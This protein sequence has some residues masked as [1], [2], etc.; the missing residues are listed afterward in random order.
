MNPI[1]NTNKTLAIFPVEA[2]G[3]KSEFTPKDPKTAIK[4][5]KAAKTRVQKNKTIAILAYW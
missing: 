3:I 2:L 1:N 5:K 4:A